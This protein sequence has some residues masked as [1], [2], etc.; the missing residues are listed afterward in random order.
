MNQ[1]KLKLVLFVGLASLPVTMVW[2]QYLDL[3]TDAA[4]AEMGLEETGPAVR[5]LPG[6]RKPEKVYINFS[7]YGPESELQMM[8]ESARKAAGDVEIVQVTGRLSDDIIN[9]MEVLISRCNPEVLAKAPRLRW[10]Q[11]SS[12]GIEDCLNPAVQ[13]SHFIMTNAQH[14]SGPPIAEHALA[15]LM[16]M[17]R[18]LHVFH[19]AQMQQQWID[20]NI[21]Y[22]IIE[23]GG[24]TMLIAGLGGIGTELAKRAHAL[25]M[26]VL[27]TRNSSREGPDF[28]EYVGLSDE[29]YELAKRADVVVNAL[30][31]TND[32]RGLFDKKF[33]DTVKPGAFFISFGRGESTVTADLIA[34]LKDGRISGAGLDVTDPEPLP[35]GHE[36]WTL[37]NVIIT[38]HMAS[39]TDQGRWRRWVVVQEN[40]RRYVNGDKLLNVVDKKLGY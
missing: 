36:L 31:L 27:A 35:T 13:E 14:T 9:N 21:D 24:K 23:L 4:I 33:F 22:P 16:M 11:H 37:P 32:T 7:A 30:P 6:W 34:A 10:H 8:L 29:L 12:H 15:L 38:P 28:V 5:D 20:R 25:G 26:T 40:L 2:S 17:T 39:T 18:G 19:T 1:L 3:D